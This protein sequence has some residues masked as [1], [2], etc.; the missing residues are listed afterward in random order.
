MYFGGK[1]YN[2]KVYVIQGNNLSLIG[3]NWIVLFDSWEM[4]IN[5]IFTKLE[6]TE[7]K[8]KKSRQIE[9]FN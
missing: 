5:S 4:P 7:R 1:K 8:K 2:S 6:A 3:I 9:N